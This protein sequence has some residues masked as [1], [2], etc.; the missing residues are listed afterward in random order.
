MENL[1]VGIY[2]G[3]NENGELMWI[4]ENAADENVAPNTVTYWNAYRQLDIM[5]GK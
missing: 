1:H 2:V 5:E 4:H 3:T